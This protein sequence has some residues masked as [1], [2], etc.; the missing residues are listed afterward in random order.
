NRRLVMRG[1]VF[2]IL[3]GTALAF[4]STAANAAITLAIDSPGLNTGGSSAFAGKVTGTGSAATF[5]DDFLFNLTN[6]D[7]LDGHVDTL[8]ING[9]LD[10]DFTHIFI[11]SL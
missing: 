11:D 2:G 9:G 5:S 1:A 7:L 8:M 4:G 10:I 3:A 6:T